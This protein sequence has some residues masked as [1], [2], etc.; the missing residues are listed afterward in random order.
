[1]P[2]GK[3]DGGVYI[4]PQDKLLLTFDEAAGMMNMSRRRFQDIARTSGDA[5]IRWNGTRQLVHRKYL[6]K[7]IDENEILF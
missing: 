1:M 5:F 4:A 6:E 7:F 3:E 2:A